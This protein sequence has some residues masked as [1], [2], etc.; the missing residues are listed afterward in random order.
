MANGELAS[1]K[2]RRRN[3]QWRKRSKESIETMASG[4]VNNN[5]MK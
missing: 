4:G 2:H 1:E 5:E 3:R